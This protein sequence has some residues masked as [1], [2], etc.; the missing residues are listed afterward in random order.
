MPSEVQILPGPP[1]NVNVRSG[2]SRAGW[3]SPGVPEPIDSDGAASIPGFEFSERLGAGGFGTVFRASDVR[4]GRDVAIK[5]LA[6]MSDEASQRRFDRECRAMGRLAGHPNIAVV[7]TSGITDDGR[8]FIAM[9]LLSG[10]SLAERIRRDGPLA[11]AEAVGLGVALCDAL[12]HAHDGGVLHLDMKPENV[13]FSQFDQPKIVDF[14]IAAVMDDDEG[15]TTIRATPSYADPVVLDG[16][17]GTAL[18]DVYGVGATLYTALTGVAPYGDGGVVATLRRIAVGTT[19]R[20]QRPDLNGVIADVIERAMAHD[21]AD[22]PASPRELRRSLESAA[23]ETP[24]P[25]GP[26][27]AAP[28]GSATVAAS[29]VPT[30]TGGGASLNSRLGV[31]LLVAAVAIGG[32]LLLTRNG[33]DVGGGDADAS[34]PTVVD[35]TTSVGR[36]VTLP[37]VVGR[38]GGVARTILEAA[39]L[40]VQRGAGCGSEVRGLDPAA[41]EQVERGAIVELLFEQCI[42]PDFVGLRLDEA[43]AVIEEYDGLL[44]EWP[45]HCDDVVLGQSPPAG[46]IVSQGTTIE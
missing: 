23:N 34:D 39:G 41:G 21:P 37:N 16:Q 6:P 3:Y 36:V 40:E 44:I 30:P 27:D 25:P 19:P 33:D 24:Q 4:H 46:S 17:P 42:V 2:A 18:S 26:V 43:V 32:V 28:T 35:V 15:T 12:D 20:V 22:R 5:V 10:G 13:L 7:H 9:E 29:A 38:S 1:T 11:P 45:D 14:G 8:P 31:G